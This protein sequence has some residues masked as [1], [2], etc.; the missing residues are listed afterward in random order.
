MATDCNEWRRDMAL[1]RRQHL[2]KQGTPE[3]RAESMA[4]QYSGATI[5]DVRR[6]VG[7]PAH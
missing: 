5:A 1:R 7:K 3:P 2:I 6:W 4:A